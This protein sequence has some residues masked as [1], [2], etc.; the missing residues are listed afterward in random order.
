[1]MAQRPLHI[2]CI[3]DSPGEA[4]LMEKHLTRAGFM[5]T[6]AGD[7]EEGLAQ[8]ADGGFDVVLVD[9]RLP[10]MMGLEVLRILLEKEPLLPVIMV[11]GRGDEETAVRAMKLGAQDY[12]VKDVDGGFIEL[13]PAVIE[14]AIMRHQLVL[15]KQLAEQAA[16]RREAILEAV[17]FAA[18]QL[19]QTTSWQHQINDLLARLGEAADVSRVYLV[20][21]GQSPNGEWAIKKW[22]EWT[23]SD[24][25]ARS[26]AY[27]GKTYS[28]VGLE[29]WVSLFAQN[30]LIYGPVGA[31]PELEQTD[32]ISQ[33]VL[34]MIAVPVFVESIWWGF[35][36]FDDCKTV[37]VWEAAEIDALRT[38]ANILGAALQRQQTESA[39]YQAQRLESVGLLAGGIAHD[40]NNLLTGILSQ[41]SLALLKLPANASAKTHIQKSVQAAEQAADLVRQLLGYAGKGQFQIR[42]IDLNQLIHD[43]TGLL[44]SSTR[45][46]AD[47]Q[48]N[49]LPKGIVVEA[50]RGQ[51]QQVVM[52][53]VMNAVEAVGAGSGTIGITT[54]QQQV[55]EPL[56]VV[57]NS[58]LK[59]GS[60]ICLEIVDTGQGMKAETLSRIFDPFFTTKAT[61]RGLGLSAILGIVRA[62]NGGIQVE[63]EWGQGTVFRIFLPHSD[64]QI[65]PTVA[66]S[67]EVKHIKARIL[68]IDDESAIR[69][70]V[71]DALQTLGTDVLVA[72]NGSQG[73]ALYEQQ[74]EMIDLILLDMQMPGLN[75]RETFLRLRDINPQA[76]IILSSGYSEV[77]TIRG[78]TKK[79]V[80]AFLQKPY[81]FEK[82]VAEIQAALQ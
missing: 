61:G 19:L 8:Q 62:H 65:E 4:R 39:L 17:T 59:P 79:D 41:S 58:M 28:E 78:F 82:L 9:H 36:G 48:V 43:S 77:D 7:G 64:K 30:R 52:N 53:L 81:R 44:E 60:Y 68:L 38:P 55:I 24:V 14:Q 71:V 57:G 29:R 11:T 22:Y 10:D 66:T 34:S 18:A 54:R 56:A 1:M 80:V 42:P 45:K 3:E 76:K 2:L 69:E 63:S 51:L 12:I 33:A 35:I 16:Q 20:E 21:N 26:M 31:L 27:G 6:W 5:T 67:S 74:H 50:D 73:I 40:F 15:D 46:R 70:A 72:K 47:L 25:P 37:R 49:L 13:L 23:A 75:G 32:F